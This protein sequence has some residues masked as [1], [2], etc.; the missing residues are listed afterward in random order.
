MYPYDNVDG[1]DRFDEEALPQMEAFFNRLTDQPIGR[2]YDH[3]EKVWKEF[4]IK[5]IGEYHDVYLKT[6]VL[7]LADVFEKFSKMCTSCYKL[8]PAHYYTS[9]R[10][11]WDAMLKMTEVKLELMRQR[12][13]HDIV[14]KGIRSGM[15]YMSHIYVTADNP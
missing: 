4:D 15:C 8:D 2:E 5:N 12:E 3:V 9:P 10:L 6:D 7:L 14:E 11:A 1:P 13:M